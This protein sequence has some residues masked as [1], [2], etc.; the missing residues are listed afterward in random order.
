MYH[1]QIKEQSLK[2]Y[3]LESQHQQ[4]VQTREPAT[5]HSP[6]GISKIYHRPEQSVTLE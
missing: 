2:N 5:A 6:I 3:I 1:W 4:N